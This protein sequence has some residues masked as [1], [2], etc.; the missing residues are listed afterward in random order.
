MSLFPNTKIKIQF[1]SP[2][3]KV[4]IGNYKTR[5]EVD[6]ALMEVKEAFPNAIPV[7]DLVKI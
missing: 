7:T 5:L 2:E 3:W 6:R 1:F 4:L